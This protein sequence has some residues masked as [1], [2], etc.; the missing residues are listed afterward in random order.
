MM[1]EQ[2]KAILSKIT[3]VVFHPLLMPS[4]LL[5]TLFYLAPETAGVDIIGLNG[6]LSL[7]AFIFV[8]T[9]ILPSLAV[10][11]LY[12]ANL[13]GSMHLQKLSD[14]RLPYFLT[15]GI[16][17][18]ISYFFGIKI[19]QTS[20]LSP[21]IGVVLVII[22]ATIFC[23]GVISLWWQISAHAVGISGVVGVFAAI[24]V[25]DNADALFYPFLISIIAWGLVLSAR[26]YLNVHTVAQ[27]VAGSLLGFIFSFAASYWFL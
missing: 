14:R 21:D 6:R 12:R 15:V 4:F 10:F 25:R 18:S 16:Y 3:S 8:A 11:Y 17:G 22:T 26:L 19:P 1:T 7:L 5:G 13:I 27:V 2:S 20:G 9:F 23:V 24:I